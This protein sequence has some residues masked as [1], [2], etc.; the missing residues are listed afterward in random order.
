MQKIILW[1]AKRFFLVIPLGV[2]EDQFYGIN[3]LR[4]IGIRTIIIS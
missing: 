4:E 3:A 2:Y 1:L